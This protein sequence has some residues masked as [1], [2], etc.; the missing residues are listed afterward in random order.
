MS[1]NSVINQTFCSPSS[2]INP[3]IFSNQNNSFTLLDI[4]RTSLENDFNQNINKNSP[5]IENCE[6]KKHFGLFSKIKEKKENFSYINE[7]N[8]SLLKLRR[9]KAIKKRR[10]N[11]AYNEISF[12]NTNINPNPSSNQNNDIK[13]PLYKDSDIFISDPFNENLI[14]MYR[15]CDNNSENDSIKRDQKFLF[16]ELNYGIVSF[17]QKNEKFFS[18][19]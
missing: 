5:I 2:Q 1:S 19:Y 16:K 12:E 13:M 17:Q 11:V 9:K 4:K 10:K 14:S 6:T 7:D 3:F 8:Y 18:Y 15:D